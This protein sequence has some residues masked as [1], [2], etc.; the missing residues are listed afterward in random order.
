MPDSAFEP[1]TEEPK[2]P[3]SSSAMPVSTR[4]ETPNSAFEPWSDT[5][6]EGATPVHID[7][8]TGHPVVSAAR[9]FTW[10]DTWPVRMAKDLY[11]AVQ[12]PGDVAAGKA[13]VQPTTPGVWTDE[14]EARQQ[15]QDAETFHRTMDLAGMGARPTSTAFGRLSGPISVLPGA[16]EKAT[17]PVAASTAAGFGEKTAGTAGE[18]AAITAEET[19]KSPLPTGVTSDNPAVQQAAAVAQEFPIAG[20]RISSKVT[21]TQEAAGEKVGEIASGMTR[22]TESRAT[23]GPQ[24]E[25]GLDTVL[26]NNKEEADA[27]YGDLRSQLPVGPNGYRGGDAEIASMPRMKAELDKQVFQRRLRGERG[28]IKGNN[29]PNPERGFEDLRNIQDAASFNGVQEARHE[30]YN[31]NRE[32][33][34]K[35]RYD[36][37]YKAMTADMRELV[38]KSAQSNGMDPN[39]AVAAFDRAE[40]RYKQIAEENALIRDLQKSGG[41]KAIGQMMTATSAKSGDFQKLA[42]LKQVMPPEKFDLIG[43]TALGEMGRTGDQFSLQKFNTAW[44]KMSNESK[45]ILYDPAHRKTI[46]DIAEMAQ[47]IDKSLA[48]ANRSHTGGALIQFE[49]LKTLG[50][51]GAAALVGGVGAAT[52][53]ITGGLGAGVPAAVGW[54]LGNKARASSVRAFMASR[55]GLTTGTTPSKVAVY[56]I[57]MRNL[58]HTLNLP[59]SEVTQIVQDTLPLPKSPQPTQKSPTLQKASIGSSQEKRPVPQITVHPAPN[60]A[61]SPSEEKA[62]NR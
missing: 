12:L 44:N 33:F 57:A 35:G 39:R 21:K 52:T 48:K 40:T 51:I 37:I 3:P 25:G 58:A 34:D 10:R 7:A 11:S 32:G 59:P 41:E 13:T 50:E 4:G 26:K 31:P 15:M 45:A 9:P 62:V 14:D 22:G 24:F 29:S 47:H 18:R 27:L 30:L 20:A 61:Q 60:R 36:Q 42:Q 19:L 46:D 38:G 53:G 54:M 1:W 2:T 55:A 28:D 43:G 17:A 6:K 23:A 5:P 8:Q 16:A 56:N 49:I